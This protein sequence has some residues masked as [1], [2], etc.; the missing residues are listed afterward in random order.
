MR[1]DV[2]DEA[3][4][5]AVIGAQC[6]GGIVDSRMLAQH[7]RNLARLDPVAA[8]LDLVV[9]TTEK[10]E[11]MHVCRQARPVTGPIPSRRIVPVYRSPS[12]IAQSVCSARPI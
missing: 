7:R 4:L 2:A 8:Q 9:R 10:F 11:R 3:R 6:D 12:R 1:H 5:A